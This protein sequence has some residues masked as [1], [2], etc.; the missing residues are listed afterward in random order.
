M[1]QGGMNNE[2]SKYQRPQITGGPNCV[3][4]IISRN[5]YYINYRA[6]YLIIIKIC[7]YLPRL[8]S[9]KCVRIDSKFVEYVNN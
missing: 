2:K 8:F 1:L 4:L 9:R 3:V 5:N 7:N 6:Y